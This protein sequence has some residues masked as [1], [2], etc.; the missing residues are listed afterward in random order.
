MSSDRV[1][2]NAP[3]PCGSGRK[4]K[5]CCGRAGDPGTGRPNTAPAGQPDDFLFPDGTPERA[6]EALAEAMRATG[7]D[8]ALVHAFEQ[9]GLLVGEDNRH[10]IPPDALAEWDRAVADYRRRQAADYPLATVARYGPDD[11]T[12]TKVVAAVFA[13]DGA[14]PV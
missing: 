14:D 8:P 5:R 6:A 11:R 9:T 7:I 12:A 3:C 13:H 10:L 4:F 1:S 2:R